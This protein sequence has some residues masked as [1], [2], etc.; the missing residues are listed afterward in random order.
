MKERRREC[1]MGGQ[2]FIEEN[3]KKNDHRIRARK[4][5]RKN[6]YNNNEGRKQ[7]QLRRENGKSPDHITSEK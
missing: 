4:Q 3:R 6:S 2:G 7:K 5:K 1:S